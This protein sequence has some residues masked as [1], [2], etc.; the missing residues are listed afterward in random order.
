MTG[1][2]HER[3]LDIEAIRSNF[4]FLELQPYGKPIIYFDN[5]ASAQK[6]NLV[7]DRLSHF[8]KFEYFRM[9]LGLFCFCGDLDFGKGYFHFL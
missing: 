6:P 5:A 1:V 4:T 7:V 3:A 2:Q 8:Y 9:F